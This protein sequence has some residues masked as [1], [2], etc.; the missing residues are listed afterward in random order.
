MT[1]S[2]SLIVKMHLMVFGLARVYSQY[3]RKGESE[4]I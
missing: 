1:A 3:T 4:G 2:M